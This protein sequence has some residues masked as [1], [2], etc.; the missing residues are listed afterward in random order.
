LTLD[1]AFHWRAQKRG[2]NSWVD[3]GVF[4]DPIPPNT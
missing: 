4:I 1:A 3:L 2:R